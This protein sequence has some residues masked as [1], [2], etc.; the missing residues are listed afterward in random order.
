MPTSV[1]SP[2]LSV[3]LP[4]LPLAVCSRAPRPSAAAACRGRGRGQFSGSGGHQRAALVAS[5]WLADMHAE[6]SACP[7]L[8]HSCVNRATR[9]PACARV[10]PKRRAPH[11]ALEVGVGGARRDALLCALRVVRGEEGLQGG[12]AAEHLRVDAAGDG[13][14]GGLEVEQQVL[15]PPPCRGG[16]RARTAPGGERPEPPWSTFGA[17][18]FSSAAAS[19]AAAFGAGMPISGAAGARNSRS[20]TRAAWPM[21][22]PIM[23]TPGYSLCTKSSVASAWMRAGCA[24]DKRTE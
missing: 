18:H 13:G 22:A 4:P 10:R 21:A 11:Q 1:P 6:T 12:A 9:S 15:G 23:V 19:G 7:K 5:G 17:L 8:V 2:R 3:A 14:R 24:H 16:G 20:T